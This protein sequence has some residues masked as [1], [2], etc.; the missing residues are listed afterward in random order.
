MSNA[1]YSLYKH[2]TYSYDAIPLTAKGINKIEATDT[3]CLSF[4]IHA[5]NVMK[6]PLN[7]VCRHQTGVFYTKDHNQHR[8]SCR[9]FI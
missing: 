6:T 7:D 4:G 1:P 8:C 5:Y 9:L 2:T 3:K